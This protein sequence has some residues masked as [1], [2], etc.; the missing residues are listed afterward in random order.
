MMPLVKALLRDNEWEPVFVDFTS[1]VF[2]KD[3][4]ENREVIAEAKYT[5]KKEHFGETML[6]MLDRQIQVEPDY[7]ML[8]IAKGDIYLF[9]EQVLDAREAYETALK[10]APFNTTAKQSLLQLTAMGK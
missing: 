5:L 3:T 9:M 7:A 10:I 4:P 2:V 8:Y 1:V 6:S